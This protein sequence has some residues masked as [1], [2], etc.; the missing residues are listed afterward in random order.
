MTGHINNLY[1]TTFWMMVLRGGM[2]NT[3][4][5]RELQV[6]YPQDPNGPLIISTG[7]SDIAGEIGNGILRQERNPVQEVWHK[8]QQRAGDVQER[9][10]GISPGT[11]PF[12]AFLDWY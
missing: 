2:S 8:L 1:N 12:P 7:E 6:P 5:E 9:E 10:C 3:D 4:A 11:F